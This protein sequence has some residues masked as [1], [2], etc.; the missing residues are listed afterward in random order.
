M[1]YW[2]LLVVLVLWRV[3]WFFVFVCVLFLRFLLWSRVSSCYSFWCMSLWLCCFCSIW[4]CRVLFVF[5]VLCMLSWSFL[6]VSVLWMLCW[7]F[8]FV[9][10]SSS[11]VLGCGLGFA[12]ALLFVVCR[13]GCLAFV[14][15]GGVGSCSCPWFF[16]CGVRPFSLFCL[17]L[18]FFC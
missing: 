9:F 12:I 14:L 10:D 4:G 6:V 5:L 16:P 17:G 13:C 3:F 18:S 2:P 8:H 7:L 11:L 15:F 1:W